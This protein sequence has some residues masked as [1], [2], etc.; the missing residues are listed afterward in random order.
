MN[1]WG[2]LYAW[3]WWGG[4]ALAFLGV[5]LAR[6]SNGAGVPPSA[7]QA[8][9]GRALALMGL[10]VIIFGVSRQARLKGRD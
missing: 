6:W 2:F 9:L 7:A 10:V 8:G 3:Y 1:R 4:G 5:A